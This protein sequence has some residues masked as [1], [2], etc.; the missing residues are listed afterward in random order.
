[1]LGFL[2]LSF[3]IFEMDINSSSCFNELYNRMGVPSKKD[4]GQYFPGSPVAKNPPSKARDV[5]L[6]L[7]WATKIPHAMGN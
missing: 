2:N 4:F 3:Y 6:I 7:D 1:M 5:G